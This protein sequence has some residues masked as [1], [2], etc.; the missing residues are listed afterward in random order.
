MRR[1]MYGRDT[2]QQIGEREERCLNGSA[3]E[4]TLRK[5][6]RTLLPG[7]FE[8]ARFHS[9]NRVNQSRLSAAT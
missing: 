9:I 4:S 5:N 3:S 8:S 1:G 7:G 2:I 6:R